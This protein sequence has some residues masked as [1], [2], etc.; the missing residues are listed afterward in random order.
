M[1]DRHP[2]F[3]SSRP[4]PGY[5]EQLRISEVPCKLKPNREIRTANYDSYKIYVSRE[6]LC[7]KLHKS[8]VLSILHGLSPSCLNGNMISPITRLSAYEPWPIHREIIYPPMD[9]LGTRVFKAVCGPCSRV[10]KHLLEI[11]L[12]RNILIM[13]YY[14]GIGSISCSVR[15]FHGNNCHDICSVKSN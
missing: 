4:V 2:G 12:L 14:H 1:N 7:Y 8:H 9:W 10:E 3:S 15:T 6:L 5:D 13:E 11:H